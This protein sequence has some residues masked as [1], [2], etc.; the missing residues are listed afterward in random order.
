MKDYNVP[1][2]TNLLKYV[3]KLSHDQI[4]KFCMLSSEKILLICKTDATDNENYL[5]IIKSNKDLCSN[6]LKLPSE[7][8]PISSI[9]FLKTKLLDKSKKRMVFI[10]GESFLCIIEIEKIKIEENNEHSLKLINLLKNNEKKIT[11]LASCPFEKESYAVLSG[12]EEGIV[13]L[14]KFSKDNSLLG[15]NSV[16]LNMSPEVNQEINNDFFDMI[17]VKSITSIVFN[18][19][20]DVLA[21]GNSVSNCR[22]CRFPTGEDINV[23]YY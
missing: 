8:N 16:F 21:V 7:L 14:W 6:I 12:D 2:K 17:S 9:N 20:N 23:S 1:K 5:K 19:K 3:S 22:I 4:Q 18:K 10:A 15:E 11:A 13:R